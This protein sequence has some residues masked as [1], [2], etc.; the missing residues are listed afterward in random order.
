MAR[1]NKDGN[2]FV[3]KK[4]GNF[5]TNKGAC[6]DFMEK[7]YQEPLVEI[8][9]MQEEVIRTSSGQD[10]FDDGYQDPNLNFKGNN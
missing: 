3:Y 1:K 10:P 6:M 9:S 8:I 7:C 2:A 4:F 5:E